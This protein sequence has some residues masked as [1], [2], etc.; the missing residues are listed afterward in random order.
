MSN[1]RRFF[2]EFSDVFGW[3]AL[4][5]FIVAIV[6]GFAGALPAMLGGFLVAGVGALCALMGGEA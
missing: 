2:Y 4:V 6:G 1:V 3:I 5:G